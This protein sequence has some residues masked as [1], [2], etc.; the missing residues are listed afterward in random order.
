MSCELSCQHIKTQN[1]MSKRNVNK[2]LKF[3]TKITYRLQYYKAWHIDC[4]TLSSIVLLPC[5]IEHWRKGFVSILLKADFRF[6]Y[7]PGADCK[8]TAVTNVNKRTTKLQHSKDAEAVSNE[9]GQKGDVIPSCITGA[10]FKSLLPKLVWDRVCNLSGLLMGY[11]VFA[12]ISIYLLSRSSI[13]SITWTRFLYKA[14]QVASGLKK[15]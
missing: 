1:E 9:T 5:H 15:G 3:I 10:V 13:A 8:K 11:V 12:T 4:E 2:S 7:S 14:V 6:Q